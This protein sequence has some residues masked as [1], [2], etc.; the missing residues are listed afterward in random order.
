MLQCQDTHLF[1]HNVLHLVGICI[2]YYD[3]VVTFTDEISYIWSKPMS[4]S[5]WLFML[6]RYFSI[7]SDVAVNWGN[8]ADFKSVK[9][10]KG[11][12][13][14]RQLMLVVAQVIVCF[15]CF[16]RTYALY[17]RS[18]RIMAL[19][20]SVALVLFILAC[21]SLVGQRSEYSITHG[22]H[23][24]LSKNSAIHLAVAW[25]ALFAYDCMIF[26]L[27]IYKT[28]QERTRSNVA[29]LNSLMELIWR[30][31]AI[32]FAVM[33]SVNAANTLTFYFLS[34]S[35]KGILSTFASSVS[36]TMMSR[37]MLNLHE[38]ASIIKP[39]PTPGST[40]T[41]DPSNSTLLFTSRIAMPS[42]VLGQSITDHHTI[43]EHTRDVSDYTNHVYQG[44]GIEEE[45][46]SPDSEGIELENM[47]T[48]TALIPHR[49]SDRW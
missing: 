31:G 19:I 1:V 48:P 14:F 2:L 12:A 40:S 22:C 18:K 4:H 36:V 15:I 11:Y 7:L 9:A 3:Y 42:T 5:S 30:D 41:S 26:V 39:K 38:T 44:F 28:Y 35:L 16:L 49:D 43:S 46:L 13:F 33:A 32:Y 21:W 45:G 23:Q 10:C 17:G 47:S 24:A 20:L 37:I 27:T 8:F 6:N 29:V 25:E 34:P